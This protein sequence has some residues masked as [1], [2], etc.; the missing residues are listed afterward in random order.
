M[1]KRKD[2]LKPLQHPARTCCVKA[3]IAHNLCRPT[4]AK[5]DLMN[6]GLYSGPN[7]VQLPLAHPVPRQILCWLYATVVWFEFTKDA[8]DPQHLYHAQDQAE[9]YKPHNPDFHVCSLGGVP[10]PV[11]QLQHVAHH[12]QAATQ[13]SDD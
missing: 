3:F 1:N 7:S 9:C 10:K 8:H 12:L 4:E 11:S 6:S 2:C 5:C 13:R